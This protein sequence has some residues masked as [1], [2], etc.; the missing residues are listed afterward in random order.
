MK[1]EL[2]SC[3]AIN[4]YEQSEPVPIRWVEIVWLNETTMM[5][6]NERFYVCMN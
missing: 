6:K 5:R 2:W 3:Q 1:Q 4:V